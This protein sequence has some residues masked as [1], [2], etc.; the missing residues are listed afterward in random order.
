MPSLKLYCGF[1]FNTLL[2]FE[3]SIAYLKS[4]PN[5][6]STKVIKS[7]QS[8]SRLNFSFIKEQI[9]FVISKFVN[10]SFAPIQNVSLRDFSLLSIILIIAPQKSLT[11][12]QSLMF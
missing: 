6:S 10:S 9:F 11:K 3:A 8:C 7:R 12:I 2:I 4:C 5:L 1:Q